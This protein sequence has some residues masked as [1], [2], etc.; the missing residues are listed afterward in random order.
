MAKITLQGNPCNTNGE[1][2]AVGSSLTFQPVTALNHS[3]CWLRKLMA[4]T[5]VP[6]VRRVMRTRRLKRASSGVWIRSFT[7][8]SASC[9]VSV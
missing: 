5:R 3:P 6:S 2:P 4:A 8:I 1:L 7:C 9:S